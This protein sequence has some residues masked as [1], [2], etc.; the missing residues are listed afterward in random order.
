MKELLEQG[1]T[2]EQ[3]DSLLS[4]TD[5]NFQGGSYGSSQDF[6]GG[7]QGA[8]VHGELH[9]RLA[10]LKQKER[11][12]VIAYAETGNA[13]E[14]ARRA[15]WSSKSGNQVGHVLLQRQDIRECLRLA[16][17]S[18]GADAAARMLR[19]VDL[20][21]EMHSRVKDKSLPL[22]E[23][24]HAAKVWA[25]SESILNELGKVSMKVEVSA[26]RTS[27]FTAADAAVLVAANRIKFAGS[28]KRAL[29]E[30]RGPLPLEDGTNSAQ[31]SPSGSST[32]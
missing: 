3:I 26:S 22:P 14:S 6:W 23:R 30:G 8:V 20:A 28:S 29:E 1:I 11:R 5:P 10:G 27:H 2:Q 25:D 16:V 4:K 18:A 7:H 17:E 13:S 15:G 21:R 19:A 24:T 9:R 32:E 12:F 31:E